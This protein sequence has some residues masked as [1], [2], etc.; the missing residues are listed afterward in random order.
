[1][2]SKLMW[3]FLAFRLGWASLMILF[4]GFLACKKSA[5]HTQTPL[6][7]MESPPDSAAVQ[8]F[9]FP[10]FDTIPVLF[11]V[12]IGCYFE[13]MDTIVKRYDTLVSYPISEH[14]IV[15][16]NPW[17]ID[18]LENTD[19]YRL[20]KRGIFNYDNR[21]L[22]VLKKGDTIFI[23]NETKAQEL[24]KFQSET[25]LDLNIPEYRLRI[26]HGSTDTLNSF[27][28]RI[29]QNK[30]RYLAMAGH[31]VNLRTS[32]GTGEIV[33]INKYPVFINPEDNERLRETRRDDGKKTR[34][35][36]I[37][38]LEPELNGKRLGQLIHPTTNPKSLGK[39]YSN[40]C[41]G[42]R[43]ADAWR[44]YYAAPVGTKVVVRYDLEV[45]NENG[46]T[47]QLKDVYGY[48]RKK[49]KK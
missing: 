1:M 37:P 35:P 10:A 14:L 3:R 29:G 45:V 34:P 41:I 5:P 15:Q 18:T 48:A 36:Q 19:Y 22:V 46:D 33:R 26:R 17:I 40:G 31:I 24:L 42:T 6:V 2:K 39:P 8:P 7:E 11:D 27:P 21:E 20:I 30:V 25:W 12:N 16:S 23:P 28:V 44:I 13:F 43:E 32:T 38:W 49:K 47:V 4:A 9:E